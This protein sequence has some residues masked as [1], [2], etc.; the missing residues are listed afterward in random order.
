VIPKKP[1][2]TE[3]ELQALITRP[4]RSAAHLSNWGFAWTVH[5]GSPASHKANEIPQKSQREYKLA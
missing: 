1:K 5:G 2:K 3:R 4:V